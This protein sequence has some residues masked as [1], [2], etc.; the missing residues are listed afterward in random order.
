MIGVVVR[1]QDGG[2]LQPVSGERGEHRTCLA[3][4]DDGRAHRLCGPLSWE[5]DQPDII[6]AEGGDRDCLYH[7]CCQGMPVT[8]G[9]IWFELER[10]RI[11]QPG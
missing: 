9:S 7:V 4:V 11:A 6:V 8:F 10:A 2:W 5:G 3:R 1:D